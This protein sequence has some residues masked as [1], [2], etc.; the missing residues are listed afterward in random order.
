MLTAITDPA[1]GDRLDALASVTVPALVLVGE[2][3]TPFLKPSHRMAEAIPGAELAVLPDGGHSPQFESPDH[4]WKALSTF[5][6]RV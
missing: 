6:E 4:W 3:D 2:Q 5:L 1:G